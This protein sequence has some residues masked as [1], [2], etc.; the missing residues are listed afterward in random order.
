[1]KSRRILIA[2]IAA[3]LTAP[4]AYGVVS[5]QVSAD[6]AGKRESDTT[7]E[8]A[9]DAKNFPDEEFRSLVTTTDLDANGYLSDAERK[10]VNWLSFEE[11]NVRSCKG[12]EFFPNLEQFNCEGNKI[13]EMDLL[14]LITLAIELRG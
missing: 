4:L 1:M 5:G 11:G 3:T 8:I 2:L 10:A 9:I 14:Y 6:E 13:Q 12:I 7:A